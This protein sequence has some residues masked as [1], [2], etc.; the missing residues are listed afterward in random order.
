MAEPEDPGS[1]PTGV[2]ATEAVTG[3]GSRSMGALPDRYAVGELLGRGGMG[4][5]RRF[6]DTRIGRDVA[7]K[8]M[9]AGSS[10]EAHERFLR[11]AR[12]QG[13]LEH[14]A[15]VPVY[16]VG[17]GSSPWFTMKQLRG[18][19]LATVLQRIAAGDKEVRAK[20]GRRR[21]LT[22]FTRA[23]QAVAFAHSKGVIHRDLKPGNVQFGDFGEVYV[24]DWGIAKVRDTIERAGGQGMLRIGDSSQTRDG[25]VL[26]TLGYMPPEQLEAAETVDRR[27]DVYALGAVLFEI[28]A[29]ERLHAGDDVPSLVHATMQGSDARPS[30]RAPDRNVPPELDDICVRATA[31]PADDRYPDVESMVADLERYLDGDRDLARRRTLA[32]EHAD[33]ARQRLADGL[34]DNDARAL[35]MREAGQA[36]AFDPSN[37]EAAELLSR[38]LLEPP[39]NIPPEIDARMDR[40]DDEQAVVQARIG[41]LSGVGWLLLVPVLVWMGVKSWPLVAIFVALMAAVAVASWRV[42]LTRRPSAISLRVIS[43]IVFCVIAWSSVIFGPFVLTPAL[44]AMTVGMFMLEPDRGEHKWFLAGGIAVVAI[45]YALE[46]LGIVEPSMRVSGDTLVLYGRVAEFEPLPTMLILL[47]S[48]L[49]A[50]M[51]I[52]R[53]VATVTASL[54][55]TRRRL[56]LH[57]WHLD[58]LLPRK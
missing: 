24:L 50:V 49:A 51:V 45:P 12:L 19:T 11:E 27:A 40:E 6:T 17:E 35:A 58:Q 54:R 22:D 37:A 20:F 55:S 4:E 31:R 28:L 41:A 5:V 21:L 7:L 38:L 56:A 10:D 44:A 29:G 8:V 14:P 25:S 42:V 32:R 13:Q 33:K 36:I 2:A 57:A 1:A 30:V 43:S 34:H 46:V 3:S 39:R 53:T 26:G 15:I 23:A 47:G 52:G 16:D 9:R 18:M 48:S